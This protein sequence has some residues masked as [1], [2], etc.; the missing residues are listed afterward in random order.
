MPDGGPGGAARLPGAPS[1]RVAGRRRRRWPRCCRAR[2]QPARASIRRAAQSARAGMRSVAAIVASSTTSDRPSEHSSSRSPGRA[3]NLVRAGSWSGSPSRAARTSERCGWS[4]AASGV[5]SPLSI[6]SCTQESSRVSWVSAP[7]LQQVGARVAD[8]GHHAALVAERDGRDRRAHPRHRGAAG[9]DEADRLVAAR[10]A[11]RERILDA[12]LQPALVDVHE[13]VD[14]RPA[15]HLA[16]RR[17]A[18]AVGDRRQPRA[19]EHGVLV[20]GRAGRRRVRAVHSQGQPRHRRDGNGLRPLRA[21][22][23]PARRRA[24][25]SGAA[26]PASRPAPARPCAPRRGS[27]ACRS[28]GP[29][30]RAG[31]RRPRR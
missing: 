1:D 29:R 19:G 31:G 5:S 4:R 7:S 21:R 20:V 6:M 13:R 16:R 10:D 26:R 9:G 11:R 15:R 23:R 30:C 24:R 18:D 2:R 25:R 27:R 22:W 3:S 28:R 17:A 12:S 8:V 14:Q